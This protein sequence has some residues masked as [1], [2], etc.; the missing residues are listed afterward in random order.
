MDPIPALDASKPQPAPRTARQW[1]RLG[2]SIVLLAAAAL[3]I[4]RILHG[5]SADLHAAF[6][7]LSVTRIVIGF[8]LATLTLACPTLYHVLAVERL[9]PT[10]GARGHIAAA[11]S[12]SQLVRYVPGKVFG[13]LFEVNY[14]RGA[15]SAN[16]LVLANTVQM[17]YQYASNVAGALSVAAVVFSGS[18]WFWTLV[19]IAA[20]A[21]FLAHRS[22]WCERTLVWMAH[23]IPGLRGTITAS[24]NPKHAAL[25][26]TLLLALEWVFFIGMWCAIDLGIPDLMPY[27]LLAACYAVASMLG[28]FAV[29]MPSGLVIRE[30]LFVWMAHM[31]GFDPVAL[32]A[33]A[34]IIRIWL[35]GGDILVALVFGVADRLRRFGTC[36]TLPA[37]S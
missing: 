14:L 24:A 32:I 31:L 26:T 12:L 37:K 25:S 29:V 1:I 13:V 11:Y 7:T 19:G 22:G 8:I 18:Q 9:A 10:R 36:M 21:F 33:Y 28:G 6:A 2:L 23:R 35:T 20:V 27:V 34:A 4:G 15:V 5:Q 17:F 3:Y 30:G 16:A